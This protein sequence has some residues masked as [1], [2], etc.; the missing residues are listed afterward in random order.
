LTLSDVDSNH[1]TSATVAIGAG[2]STGNDVLSFNSA[3]LQPGMTA[4]YANN[5]VLT[6]TGSGSLADYQQILAS[7]TF[8]TTTAGGRT[9]GFTVFD[10]AVRSVTAT[11]DNLSLDNLSTTGFRLRACQQVTRRDCR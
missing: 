4:T 8:Q 11:T 10:G 9:I 1:V 7:V 6:I 2:F 5:G 3:L